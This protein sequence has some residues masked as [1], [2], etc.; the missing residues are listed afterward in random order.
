[1]CSFHLA[2]IVYHF[3]PTSPRAWAV[4]RVCYV[5]KTSRQEVMNDIY[6]IK[7][8]CYT[9]QREV[10]RI[11]EDQHPPLHNCEN[12]KT[13]KVIVQYWVNFTLCIPLWLTDNI[14][15]SIWCIHNYI[16]SWSE[17]FTLSMTKCFE[18]RD[19]PRA[20]QLLQKVKQLHLEQPVPF[21]W[22]SIPSVKLFKN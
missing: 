21:D 16:N 2:N 5:N 18:R 14:N 3:P 4:G 10:T 12:I 17:S 8:R 7:L 1:M 22:N 19:H 11:P 13:C 9:T 20:I 6:Q 15:V